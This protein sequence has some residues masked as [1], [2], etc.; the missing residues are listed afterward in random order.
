[1]PVV[2]DSVVWIPDHPDSAGAEATET[3]IHS[4]NHF[5]FC[6]PEYPSQ[7]TRKIRGSGTYY[8]SVWVNG[9]WRE[10]S[11]HITTAS[12]ILK[13]D[14]IAVKVGQ[15]VTFTPSWSD[16]STISANQISNWTW[17]PD[18]GASSSPCSSGILPCQATINASGK[19]RVTVSRN[20][21]SR[22]AT[23][24][25]AVYAEFTL[26]ANKVAVYVNDTI[27][28]T[29]KLNGVSH[30][31]ARWRFIPD[32]LTDTVACSDGVT[33]CKKKMLV[34]GTMW[35]YLST[36]S[37][38]GDSAKVRVGAIPPCP[39]GDPVL[40]T[41]EVRWVLLEIW[42]KSNADST[43]GAG[44]TSADSGATGYKRERAAWIFKRPDSTFFAEEIEPGS[45]VSDECS[46]ALPAPP[47]PIGYQ[48]WG[49]AHTHPASGKK[50]ERT[51]GKCKDISGGSVK[52]YSTDPGR[53][54]GYASWEWPSGG[55]SQSD[56]DTARILG[57]E[58][59][60]MNKDN[61]IYRLP[62]YTPIKDQR[63]DRQQRRDFWRGNSPPACNW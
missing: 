62:A 46:I 40:D 3:E 23:V 2:G 51:F 24:H 60:V 39:T 4:A 58:V 54:Q 17:F 34:S 33:H 18:S 56:W 52:R 55:G 21:V 8:R 31:A 45:Y 47:Q 29:P 35:A 27:T 36:T 5:D 9:T 10:A 30:P 15:A 44:R 11:V 49:V 48:V 1:M 50:G 26:E 12:L 38:V 42:K 16:G 6:M 25:V 37:G 57:L 53:P 22:T 28:F 20:G 63:N 41:P 14:P 32:T 59:Y 43:P 61:E 7:C 19:M 13:A